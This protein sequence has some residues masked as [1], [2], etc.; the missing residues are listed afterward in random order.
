MKLPWK[1][2]VFVFLLLSCNTGRAY[3]QTDFI[4]LYEEDEILA[5]RQ[6]LKNNPSWGND[7]FQ[8]IFIKD[9]ARA[10]SQMKKIVVADRNTPLLP[11][12]FERIALYQFANGLYKTS[13]STF[14]YLA[15]KYKNTRYGE[16]GLFYVARS[17]QAI[18]K[19]DSSH[20]VLE[21]LLREYPHSKY[22]KIALR[23]LQNNITAASTE[24]EKNEPAKTVAKANIT[25]EYTIQTGAFSSASHAKIQQQ[26]LENKGYSATIYQKWVGK[27]RFYVVCMGKFR[28]KKKAESY[29]R[30]IARK[31][32]LDYHIVDLNMLV[33]YR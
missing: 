14:Y 17:F 8:A 4:K 7:F 12:I 32:H 15:E 18:G 3:C 23:E 24:K 31:Y 21:K 9:A 16:L 27:R 29:G 30:S 2:I 13:Q 20:L 1:N 25:E 19:T 33:L 22:S 5:L 28:E 6:Q 10:I 11:A 26:F